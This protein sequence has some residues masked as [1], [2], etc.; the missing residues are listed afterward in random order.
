M[1]LLHGGSRGTTHTQRLGLPAERDRE[2]TLVSVYPSLSPSHRPAIPGVQASSTHLTHFASPP[3]SSPSYAVGLPIF[4]FSVP[5]GW[6]S[7]CFGA[8]SPCPPWREHLKPFLQEYTL[9]HAHK[10]T[11]RALAALPLW[12]VSTQLLS[13]LEC[14]PILSLDLPQPLVTSSKI[15]TACGN[16]LHCHLTKHRPSWLKAIK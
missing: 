2:N 8:H 13:P 7:V 3:V 11:H 1:G 15:C 5:S 14:K 16:P 10:H 6:A 12:Q 4:I 9:T